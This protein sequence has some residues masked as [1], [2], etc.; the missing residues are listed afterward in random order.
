[1]SHLRFIFLVRC[2][3]SPWPS[4]HNQQFPKWHPWSTVFSDGS[5]LLQ[6]SD[7]Q[8]R[9]FL[10]LWSSV[11]LLA[12]SFSSLETNSGYYMLSLSPDSTS[13]YDPLAHLDYLSQYSFVSYFE[14]SH[15][16]LSEIVLICGSDCNAALQKKASCNYTALLSPWDHIYGALKW[17]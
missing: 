6:S 3:F 4:A 2:I 11:Y 14:P 5:V 8:T 1:M 17:Y 12:C 13:A 15:A 9:Y 16:F 10:R 7:S